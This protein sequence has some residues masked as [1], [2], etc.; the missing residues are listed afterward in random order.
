M[1][2]R[3]RGL[4]R[5]RASTPSR[6]FGPFYLIIFIK[7]VARYCLASAARTGLQVAA[8][9]VKGASWNSTVI[10]LRKLKVIG[11]FAVRNP[12]KLLAIDDKLARMACWLIWSVPPGFFVVPGHSYAAERSE[13]ATPR[14]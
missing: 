1:N 14:R 6:W 11:A 12:L 3:S 7:A 13:P 9:L 2:V 10:T 8:E 5:L 4:T